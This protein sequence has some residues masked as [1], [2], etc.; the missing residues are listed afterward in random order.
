MVNYSVDDVPVQVQFEKGLGRKTFYRHTYNSGDVVATTQ[1]KII[2]VSRI[3][4]N[5]SRNIHDTLP[6]YSVTVYTT[7]PS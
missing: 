1:A 3:V 6:G 4:K 7:D 5:V 2:G